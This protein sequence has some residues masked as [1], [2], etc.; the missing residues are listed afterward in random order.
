MVGPG[1]A[2][3]STALVTVSEYQNIDHYHNT[4]IGSNYDEDPSYRITKKEMKNLEKI[5]NFY[6]ALHQPVTNSVKMTFEEI[7]LQNKRLQQSEL[8]KFC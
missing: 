6:A 7:Q 3:N 4:S 8:L 2:A 5:F 1:T